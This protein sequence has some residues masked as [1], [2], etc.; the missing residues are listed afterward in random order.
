MRAEESWH[1]KMGH[2]AKQSIKNLTKMA[3]GILADEKQK[4]EDDNTERI[5]HLIHKEQEQQNLLKYCTLMSVMSY[6]QL[7]ALI[8]FWMSILISQN[9][10]W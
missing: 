4:H 2:P 6:K 9:H 8:Q 10:T 7:D 1:I 3:D 5:I